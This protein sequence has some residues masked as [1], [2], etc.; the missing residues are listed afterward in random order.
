[1][2]DARNVLPCIEIETRPSP[3]ASVV[4][5]HG[6]GADGH[7]FEP[8]V[9][10][11]GLPRAVGIRFVFPHAPTRPVTVN[12]GMVMRAWYDIRVEGNARVPD[13]HGLRESARAVGALIARE[14]ERGVRAERIVL[15]GFSQGGALTLYAGLRHPE[16]LAGLIALSCSLPA[17]DALAAEAAPAGR[18]MK[19]FAGHGRYDDLVPA[20]R[21]RDAAEILNAQGYAVTWR[22]YP[23]PHSVSAQE[24]ADVSAFLQEVLK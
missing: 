9:P 16:R 19:V 13:L 22:E 8:I 20:E 5:L 17:P 21:G 15:A 7:D 23:I 14:R 4:W 18:G 1:M 10:E 24:I 12:G 2:P 6:L 11:L 3:D